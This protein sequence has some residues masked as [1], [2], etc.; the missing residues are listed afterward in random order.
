MNI[1][2][3]KIKGKEIQTILFVLR[4][5]NTTMSNIEITNEII[6]NRFLPGGKDN[7]KPRVSRT[8]KYL[9]SIGL[10]DTE[11]IGKTNFYKLSEKFGSNFYPLERQ[12]SDNYWISSYPADMMYS[13]SG[14]SIYG[15]PEDFR[16]KKK[17]WGNKLYHRINK[18]EKDIKKYVNEIEEI[19]KTYR[20]SFIEKE[21]NKKIKALKKSKVNF[22][23]K[24]YKKVLVHFLNQTDWDEESILK[25]LPPPYGWRKVDFDK[26]KE[27]LKKLLSK[28]ERNLP[29]K[30]LRKK[31]S[32]YV[33]EGKGTWHDS[34]GVIPK[35][36]GMELWDYPSF[37]REM[38]KFRD[39]E[40]KMIAKIL[41]NVLKKVWRFYPTRVSIVAHTTNTLM[42]E[43]KS[44]KF[45]ED[46]KQNN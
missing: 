21:L 13:G 29:D 38:F 7:I 8:L 24:K 34:E 28:K 3:E 27:K 33:E 1:A 23:I 32:G 18:I 45:I 12:F 14:V 37:Y 35:I 46:E 25:S 20:K 6:R 30:I 40:K 17:L 10:V 43:P 2:I 41:N 19:K 36:Y 26:D 4:K 16:N 11:N 5:S 39:K 9:K 44:R 42:L 15:L 31:Y 22:F